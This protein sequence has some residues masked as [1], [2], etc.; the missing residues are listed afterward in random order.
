MRFIRIIKI[1]VAIILLSVMILSLYETINNNKD[2]LISKQIKITFSQKDN[3]NITVLFCPKENCSKKIV[4]II[5]SA[6]ES[7]YCAF[8]DIDSKEIKNSLDNKKYLKETIK[9]IVDSDNAKYV[10]D[11]NINIKEDKRSAFMHNKFCIIDSNI[12]ITGSMNPTDNGIN[13][14]NNNVIIINSEKFAQNYKDEFNEMWTG[15]FGKGEKTRYPIIYINNTKTETYF[16]PDDCNNLAIDRIREI[17][18]KAKKNIY[19][20]TFSFTHDN[21]ANSILLKNIERIPIKGLLE[22]RNSGSQYSKHDVFSYQG[23]AVKNDTNPFSMHHKVFIVDE[24]IVISGSFNPSKNAQE[25][26]DENIVIIHDKHIAKKY[27]EEF[28]RLY[29]KTEK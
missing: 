21:I 3:G 29:N 17:I 23:I 24:E 27:I 25:R 28:E 15:D 9:L 12:T 14:N 7:V 16:C 2:K 19:F 11:L 5:D 22:K 10:K 4:S 20:M 8:F 13:K 26:N 6:K 18:S 1:A